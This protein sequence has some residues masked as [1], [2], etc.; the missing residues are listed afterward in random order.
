M[1]SLH[2]L[3]IVVQLAECDVCCAAGPG[4]PCVR[5]ASGADGMHVARFAAA[6][7]RGLITSEEFGS[8]IWALGAFTNST[9]VYDE[10]FGR[11]A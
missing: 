8:V 1:R 4:N 6:R 5:R 11:A 10:T 3:C 2:I 7:R 9:V